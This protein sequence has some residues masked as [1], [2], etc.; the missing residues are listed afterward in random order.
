MIQTACAGRAGDYRVDYCANS[1]EVTHPSAPTLQERLGMIEGGVEEMHNYI[2]SLEKRLQ[3]VLL[4]EA[5][6]AKEESGAVPGHRT[7]CEEQLSRIMEKIS[8][9]IDAIASLERRLPIA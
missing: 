2:D 8:A 3:F 1:G 4:P 5:K 7:T 9:G 6:L